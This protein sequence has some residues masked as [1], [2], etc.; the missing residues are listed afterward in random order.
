MSEPIEVLNKRLA[1]IVRGRETPKGFHFFCQI[2]SETWKGGMITIQISGT[3]WVLASAR[4]EGA[5]E[6]ESDLF[7]RYLS[8]RDLRAFVKVLQKHPFWKLDDSRWEPEDDETNIHFRLMDTS[9]GFAWDTQIWSGE[10]DRQSDLHELLKVVDLILY[11]VSDHA[12]RP[13]YK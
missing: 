12:V 10:R 4:D 13:V 5:A 11:T 7:S 9:K 8:T 1:S 6:G 2:G 3:G